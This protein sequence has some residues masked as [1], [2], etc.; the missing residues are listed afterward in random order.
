MGSLRKFY[1]K[2]SSFFHLVTSFLCIMVFTLSAC[3]ILYNRTTGII[4]RE[5]NRAN[6]AILKQFS[7]ALD[8]SFKNM[9]QL[10]VQVH[11]GVEAEI[12]S[13]N[14]YG[15]YT[16]EK[17]SPYAR[18]RAHI[19]LSN[20]NIASTDIEG[21]FLYYQKEKYVISTDSTIPSHEFYQCY[22]QGNSFTEKEWNHI[23]DSSVEGFVVFPSKKTEYTEILNGRSKT[24]VPI[25][26]SKSVSRSVAFIYSPFMAGSNFQDKVFVIFHTSRLQQILNNSRW[27]SN[28][29]FLVYGP[30]GT[31]LTATDPAYYGM[32]LSPYFYKKDFFDTEHAGGEYI[33]KV[34]RSDHTNFRYAS[35]TP[36]NLAAQPVTASQKMAFLFLLIFIPIGFSACYILSQRYYSPLK[37]LVKWVDEIA[38]Y[39]HQSFEYGNEI[40]LLERVLLLSYE[41]Q[42]KL[43]AQIRT[44]KSDLISSS[45]RDLLFGTSSQDDSVKEIFRKNDISLLSEQFAVIL[46]NVE[47]KNIGGANKSCSRDLIGFLIIHV[48]EELSGKKHKGFVVPLDAKHYA[49]LVNFLPLDAGMMQQDLLSIACYG[50]KILEETFG[51]FVTISYSAVHTETDGIRQAFQEA[52]Y[53]MEYRL[54]LGSSQIIPYQ[55]SWQEYSIYTFSFKMDH[56]IRLFL[57]ETHDLSEITSFVS[58]LFQN[59]EIN[60]HTPPLVARNF[61]YDVAGTLSKTINEI[62]SNDIPWKKDIF[63]RLIRCDTLDLFRVELTSIL[64]EYQENFRQKKNMNSIGAQVWKYINQ[65]HPDP[66]LNVNVLGDLFHLSPAYLSRIFKEQY[67]ISIPDYISNCRIQNA[68]EQLRKKDR[69]IEQI[70]EETGFLSCSVFIRVFRK[71]EGTTPGAY[72]KVFE[73]TPVEVPL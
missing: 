71:V 42:K 36:K 64:T 6:D 2:K 69:T 27:E 68:K 70:A 44:R 57:K 14:Q 17:L 9:S 23:L 39:D 15:G 72:R 33:C 41:E 46:I 13:A 24:G 67:G 22:Y 16:R 73:E 18:Y 21:I 31:L 38:L 50:K 10:A 37:R 43:I 11:T 66:M 49:C 40:D 56:F 58:E 19:F 20:F 63:S 25:Y 34:I 45:I 54:I 48:L 53:A 55:N 3:F 8:A 5:N 35:V 51:I 65:N 4:K 29:A 52:Q 1:I 26:P 60:A 12:S 62:F 59:R 47:E 32:D 28:G 61:I 7:N 30:D